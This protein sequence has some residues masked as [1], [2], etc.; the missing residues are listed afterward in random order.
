MGDNVYLATPDSTGVIMGSKIGTV[1]YRTFDN[2]KYGDFSIVELDN[3][4]E[5]SSKV[6]AGNTTYTLSGIK[7]SVPLNTVLFKYGYKTGI[8]QVLVTNTNVRAHINTD[9]FDLY[10]NGMTQATL[11][12]GDSQHGDSGDPYLAYENGNW[13][14]TGIHSGV[15]LNSNGEA[16]NVVRFTPCG[17]INAFFSL[18]NS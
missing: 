14:L 17:Y 2:E 5:S 9:G 3:G 4:V 7:N 10:V 13:Y 11:L 12:S 1:K 16:T 15:K 6:L 8:S 18:K